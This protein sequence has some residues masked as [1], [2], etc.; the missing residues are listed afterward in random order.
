MIC[1]IVQAGQSVGAGVAVVFAC[2]DNLAVLSD[3]GAAVTFAFRS[4]RDTEV[5]TGVVGWT[6]TVITPATL[7]ASG[8]YCQNRGG[9]GGSNYFSVNVGPDNLGA[10]TNLV[11]AS[12]ECGN[13]FSY[14]AVDGWCDCVPC[15]VTSCTQATHAGYSAYSIDS[16]HQA[17]PAMTLTGVA[18]APTTNVS[19]S[20]PT[21]ITFQVLLL[22][23]LLL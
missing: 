23:L 15:D 17:C 4:T 8:K 2:T 16:S 5:V 21:K 7:V 3:A 22:L 9:A 6:P 10:C 14:G 18:L 19:G 13:F 1:K 12:T 20:T 11:A